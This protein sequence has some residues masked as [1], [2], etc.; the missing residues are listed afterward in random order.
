MC[1]APLAKTEPPPMSNSSVAAWPAGKP[2][3]EI[4]WRL[5]RGEGARHCLIE[6]TRSGAFQN[7]GDRPGDAICITQLW[8]TRAAPFDFAQGRLS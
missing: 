4:A 7:A 2:T 8:H 1:V 5:R 6:P 3:L